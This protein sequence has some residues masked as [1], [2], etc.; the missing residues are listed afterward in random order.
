VRQSAH[1]IFEGGFK[2]GIMCTSNLRI[3]MN[4]QLALRVLWRQVARR[5]ARENAG[6]RLGEDL[7]AVA[8]AISEDVATFESLMV[9]LGLPRN[10]VKSRA[11]AILERIAR[12]KL[13]GSVT[14]YSELSRFSELE[15][16]VMG[17]EGKKQLWATLR[18]LADLSSRV[19]DV[20]FDLLIAR[21]EAQRSTLEPHRVTSGRTAFLGSPGS[22][23]EASAAAAARDGS[24][25]VH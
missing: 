15:F 7:V 1:A 24:M 16:L 23:A 10:R 3:Y 11:A 14:S 6:T 18:D 19:P 2:G 4:D 12:L 22:A 5:A 17:I 13:N 9:R 21:A 25:S 8:H 20:D